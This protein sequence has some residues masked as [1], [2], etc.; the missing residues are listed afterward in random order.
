M[1]LLKNKTT[2]DTNEIKVSEISG[3]LK[4]S[5]KGDICLT[6]WEGETV[7]SVVSTTNRGKATPIPMNMEYIKNPITKV[8]VVNSK[9]SRGEKR[10]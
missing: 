4:K 3:G 10:R 5:E 7:A 8:I 2:T 1:K 9:P 6:H